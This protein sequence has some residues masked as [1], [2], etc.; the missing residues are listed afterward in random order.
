MPAPEVDR[1]VC[2]DRTFAELW[3]IVQTYGARSIAELQRH[4][5]FGYRCRLCHPYV[6]RMLQTGQTRF[7]VMDPSQEERS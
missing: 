7:P 6:V 4:V 2:H 1:C 5:A 3:Q